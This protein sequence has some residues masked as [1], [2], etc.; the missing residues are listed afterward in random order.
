MIRRGAILKKLVPRSGSRVR[1]AATSKV[2][3]PSLSFDPTG[4]VSAVTRRSS[5]HTVPGFGPD[6]AAASGA[7]TAG[8]VLS[9][10][11]S[12]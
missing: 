2:V 3:A 7:F 9:R 11:R 1:I 12:G 4:T 10:P 5:I 8:A 6:C